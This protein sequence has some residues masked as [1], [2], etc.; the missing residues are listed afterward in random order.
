MIYFNFSLVNPFCKD[1]SYRHI[2]IKNGGITKNKFW[3]IEFSRNPRTLFS[4]GFSLTFKQSHAGFN[5]DFG[6]L[7][8][9]FLFEILDNR[10]WNYVENCWEEDQE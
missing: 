10:H 2:F 5:F 1:S 7:G 6:L 8:Y 4:I 9:L 3:E